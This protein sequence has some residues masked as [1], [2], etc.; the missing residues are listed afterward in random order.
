VNGDDSDEEMPILVV[1]II[2]NNF[3]SQRQETFH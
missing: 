2:E 3:V 1:K